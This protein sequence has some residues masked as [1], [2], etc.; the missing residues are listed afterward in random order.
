MGDN[1]LP[2]EGPATVTL[3]IYATADAPEDQRLWRE[4]YQVNLL[5]GYYSAR[6]GAV[7]SLDGIFIGEPR[8]LGISVD[9]EAE[10]QPRRELVSVPYA[11]LARNAAAADVAQDAVGDIGPASVQVGAG[12]SISIGGRLVID[13]DGRWQGA[14]IDAGD[15]VGQVGDAD[16]FDGHS[17]DEFILLTSD[18]AAAAVATLLEDIDVDADTLDGLDSTDF[19][20]ASNSGAVFALVMQEHGADSGLDADLLDGLDS[21][22]FLAA[23][24]SEGA[25]ALVTLED[26]ADSGLDADR[27]D[28]LDSSEFVGATDSD[29]VMTLVRAVDGPDSGLNADRLDDLDSTQFLRSEDGDAVLALLRDVDG[30]ASDLNADLLDDL[31]SS[32]FLRAG[33]ADPVMDLVR[34]ADGPDSGLNAD[35]LDDLDSTHFLRVGVAGP[36]MDL[37]L[38]SDG[39]NSTLDADRLDGLDSTQFLGV[40][41]SARVMALMQMEHGVGSGLNAD[42]LD[43]L[44]SSQ[45][46]G[47]DDS[48]RAMA[49]VQ[50]E[51]GSGSS[52]DADRL[53]GLDSTQLLGVDDSTRAMELVQME[54]GSGSG[55]DADRL[56]GLSSEQFMRADGAV[57]SQGDLTVN[58]NLSVTGSCSANCYGHMQDACIVSANSW[59]ANEMIAEHNSRGVAAARICPDGYEICP[60]HIA[61]RYCGGEDSRDRC[62]DRNTGCHQ[63]PYGRHLWVTGWTLSSCNCVRYGEARTR[64]AFTQHYGHTPIATSPG[65]VGCPAGSHMA[66]RPGSPTADWNWFICAPDG[67]AMYVLCCNGSATNKTW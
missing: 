17:I 38:D 18:D 26:G 59:T 52:L 63:N 57:S 55:L 13:A 15:I 51:H 54:H 24:D 5:D 65:A 47:V 66:I 14:P 31:D 32:A 11:L 45:F 12:G 56:D 50:M 33:E 22:Y 61:K 44:D 43:G 41:D 53:D 4:E 7:D 25:F 48:A 37:V 62:E 23:D 28:G 21:A 40:D 8:F 2:R 19:L 58:G 9:H 39:I 6:M 46:L 60:M 29:T 3:S 20:G 36:V 49:L 67:E 64:S 30:Q 1:G 34:G 16:T 10:L 27:L 35:R 42:L